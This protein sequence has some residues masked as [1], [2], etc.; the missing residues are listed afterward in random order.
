MANEDILMKEKTAPALKLV[1]KV[2][3]C[4]T[5]PDPLRLFTAGAARFY[6]SR[7]FWQDKNRET[8][9]VGF[10]RVCVLYGHSL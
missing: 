10:G 4:R 1:S 8:V 6:G 7:F 2:I 9:F 3:K 5:A